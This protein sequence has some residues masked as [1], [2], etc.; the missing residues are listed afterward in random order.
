MQKIFII[1]GLICLTCVSGCVVTKVHTMPVERYSAS[2]D[3]VWD[4]VIAY[5][6]KQKEPI[7]AADKE[8]GV[9]TTNW[10]NMHKPF[11]VK[12]YRYDVQITK[13][14]EDEVQV[15]VVSPQEKYSMGDWEETLPTE[16]RARR[17]F[18]DLRRDLRESKRIRLKNVAKRPF[19]KRER[20]IVREK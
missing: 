19:H 9:I 3:L 13:L 18:R 20:G 17:I 4:S 11:S 16:R 1:L 7:I 14:A 15:G 12:R 8:K 2:Y 10:V 5:L 6:D